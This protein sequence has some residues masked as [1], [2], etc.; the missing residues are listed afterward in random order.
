MKRN[1]N[2]QTIIIRLSRQRYEALRDANAWLMNNYDVDDD[3]DAL[4][5]LHI[6]DLTSRIADM[7]D[8]QFENA[9][10][11][12]S[13]PEAFAFCKVWNTVELPKEMIYVKVLIIDL[14]R[15]IDKDFKSPNMKIK[16]LTT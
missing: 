1:K 12:L 8:Y 3:G 11:M 10:M 13:A 14:I 9:N 7:L 4:E 2:R 6:M 16:L 5:L 15:D